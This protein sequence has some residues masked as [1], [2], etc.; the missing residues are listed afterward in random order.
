MTDFDAFLLLLPVIYL[1]DCIWLVHRHGLVF[2]ALPWGWRFLL[3]STIAGTSN[4]GLVMLNPL[5]PLGFS[6]VCNPLPVSLSADAVLAFVTCS[7]Q[8]QVEPEQSRHLCKLDTIK[9]ISSSDATV[10]ING[11]PFVTCASPAVAQTTVAALCRVQQAPRSQRAGVIEEV[12]ADSLDLTAVRQVVTRLRQR[13]GTLRILC[14]LL[15]LLLLVVLPLTFAR[16]YLL[17]YAV[18]LVVGLAALVAAIVI[19]FF[20]LHR[21]SAPEQGRYRVESVVVMS[22]CPPLAVRA[23]DLLSRHLLSRF[24]PLAVAAV[25]TDRQR[26]ESLARQ[27]LL[28]LSHPLPYDLNEPVQ[29]ETEAFHRGLLLKLL[30]ELVESQGTDPDALIAPPQPASEACKWYCPRCHSQLTVERAECPDCGPIPLQRFPAD[31]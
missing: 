20:R 5:P 10:V 15:F 11:R 19:L 2:T 18:L 30:Q 8:D 7:L 22:L 16:L 3:P 23:L 9:T 17:W 4:R 28:D 29:R 25:L 31:Q 13:T 14:N 1:S 21:S 12:L 24:H 26:F 6:F 27:V